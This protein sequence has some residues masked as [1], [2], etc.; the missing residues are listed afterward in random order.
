[1]IAKQ[2]GPAASKGT[3]RLPMMATRRTTPGSLVNNFHDLLRC[4]SF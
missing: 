2:L 1:M 4:G 3:A